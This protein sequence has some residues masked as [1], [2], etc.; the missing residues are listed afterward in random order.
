MIRSCLNSTLESTQVFWYT[1]LGI[2]LD[3]YGPWA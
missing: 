3:E 1:M 2:P